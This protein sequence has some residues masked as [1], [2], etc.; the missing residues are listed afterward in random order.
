MSQTFNPNGIFGGL[1]LLKRS[2]NR[3]LLDPGQRP[4]Y[5]ILITQP[6]VR[7][8]VANFNRAD[9]AILLVYTLVGNF[10]RNFSD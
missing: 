6:T 3:I 7:E 1:N 8:T 5:P 10:I 4:P 2:E 9:L